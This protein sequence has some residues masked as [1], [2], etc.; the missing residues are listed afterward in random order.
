M[1]NLQSAGRHNIDVADP[2]LAE[3]AFGSHEFEL[4][5]AGS[6]ARNEYDNLT[7]SSTRILLDSSSQ[8]R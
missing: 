2:T 1:M 6:R 5:I 3:S 4:G 7:E 8:Y